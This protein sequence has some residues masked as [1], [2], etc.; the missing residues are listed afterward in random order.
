MANGSG[1]AAERAN[2]F[3]QAQAAIDR[4]DRLARQVARQMIPYANIP[5]EK[6]L[7]FRHNQQ[8]IGWTERARAELAK[9]PVRWAADT[10]GVNDPDR[11]ASRLYSGLSDGDGKK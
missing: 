7:L 4:T 5:T 1:D 8:V 10:V 6:Y 3:K 9:A 2:Q 11:Q